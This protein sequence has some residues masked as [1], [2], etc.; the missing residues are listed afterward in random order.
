MFQNYTLLTKEISATHT[1][2]E[3]YSHGIDID[4][5]YKYPWINC[6]QT[7]DYKIQKMDIEALIIQSGG[8]LRKWCNSQFDVDSDNTIRLRLFA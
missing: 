2:I 3:R 4:L 8:F 7:E 5:Y 6:H 1:T